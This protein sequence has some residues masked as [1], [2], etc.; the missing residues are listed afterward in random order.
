MDYQRLTRK[1]R[2]RVAIE[3]LHQGKPVQTRRGV[4]L[5]GV[6][7]GRNISDHDAQQKGRHTPKEGRKGEGRTKGERERRKE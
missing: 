5:S 6:E 2:Q 3:R 1:E 7:R 4:E